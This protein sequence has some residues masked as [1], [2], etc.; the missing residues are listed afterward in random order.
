M[1]PIHIHLMLNHV[2]VLGAFLACALLAYALI[3]DHEPYKKLAYVILAVVGLAAPIVAVSGEKAAEGI[4]SLAVVPDP[5]VH[6]H[7]EAGEGAEIA[8]VA[9]GILAFLQLCSYLFPNLHRLRG[10]TAPLLLLGAAAAFAWSAYTANLGGKIR[11]GEELRTGGAVG[12]APA[13]AGD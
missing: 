2:P 12:G 13:E 1:N 7:E 4:E 10:R 11:H 8:L 3:R 9:L 6:A 5:A